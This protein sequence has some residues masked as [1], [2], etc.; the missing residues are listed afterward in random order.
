MKAIRIVQLGMT[1]LAVLVSLVTTS[2]LGLE[3][4][5]GY[6]FSNVSVRQRWPWDNK[7]DID[8]H[9]AKPA[10]ASSDQAVVIGVAI[11]N[12]TEAVEIS[13][14]SLAGNLAVLP[15]GYRRIVWD[16]TVNCAGQSFSQL[17]VSLSVTSTNGVPDYMVI[18]LTTGNIT[19]HDASFADEV[20]ADAYKTD[21]MALRYIEQDSATRFYIG[22]FEVTQ[23]QYEFI[24][25]VNP[26]RFKN[27]TYYAMR[28]VEQVTYN[29]LRGRVN[30]A[31]YPESNA[32]DEL[33]FFYM[34]RRLARGGNYDLPTSS[35][36]EFA[37]RAGT[38]T[39]YNDGL[40]TPADPKNNAQ[41]DVLGRYRHNGGYIDGTT[42][43][44]SSATTDNAT[45]IVGSYLPNAWGLYDM[46]GNV[47]E[48]CLE[49]F[50]DWQGTLTGR[51]LRG[52]SWSTEGDLC[53]SA[54]ARGSGT[55]PDSTDPGY[56][57]RVVRNLP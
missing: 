18:D 14:D 23:R 32:V 51:V 9:L 34:L 22:V 42:V 27:A 45:A 46:H 56:G 16:P 10:G 8:F 39:Y 29:M 53:H 43:P 36:W 25:T 57:F 40:G 44:A 54:Y 41:M 50:Y 1:A 19:Y 5:G 52:G 31:L 26:S 6:V 20:N 17:S 24:M 33:S 3:N 21:K 12:G 38:D 13:D 28:P 2:A 48:M 7:V 4:N 35:Q 49:W 37:C 47:Y 30:G 15:D 11:S 55:N